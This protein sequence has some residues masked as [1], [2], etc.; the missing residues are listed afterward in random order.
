MEVKIICKGF[1]PEYQHPDD[2]GADLYY[3]GIE[4]LVIPSRQVMLIPTGLYMQIPYG[5][6]A[7]IRPRSG[8]ALKNG[9][10]VLN[11]P[12]TI[13]SGYRNEIGVILINHSDYPF[14]VV[15]G[16]RIA[17]VVFNKIERAKFHLV[18]KLDESER[19]LEGFGST[20]KKGPVQLKISF[21]NL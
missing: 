14:T 21:P 2:A 5:Y 4:N 3:N 20:D 9:I 1:L 15:P 8:L 16:T 11:S 6:E 12:G 19:G 13:D 18:E 10:T 7:Q 17:Q